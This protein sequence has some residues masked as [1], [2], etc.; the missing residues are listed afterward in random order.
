[1]KE[2]LLQMV[3]THRDWDEEVSLYFGVKINTV[4]SNW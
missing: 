3:F 2:R 4:E 1:M